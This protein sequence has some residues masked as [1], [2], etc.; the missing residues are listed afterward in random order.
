MI[1]TES[2]RERERERRKRDKIKND[3]TERLEKTKRD[4]EIRDKSEKDKQ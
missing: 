4:G 1:I 2:H 3:N